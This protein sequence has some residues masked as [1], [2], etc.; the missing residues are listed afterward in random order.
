MA[1]RASIL[2]ADVEVSSSVEV[3]SARRSSIS[4]HCWRAAEAA[5]RTEMRIGSVIGVLDDMFVVIE[6][7]ILVGMMWFENEGSWR[8]RE[9]T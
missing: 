4:R 9:F 5:E 6:W 7:F 8:I 1:M 2:R 3:C